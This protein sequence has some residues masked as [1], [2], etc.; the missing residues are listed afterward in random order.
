MKRRKILICLT[1]VLILMMPVNVF[2]AYENLLYFAD[3][4]EQNGD[5]A[6]ASYYE[7]GAAGNKAYVGT[8]S[9]YFLIQ[10]DGF[11]ICC[12]TAYGVVC[13]VGGW[14]QLNTY[15]SVYQDYDL[16]GNNWEYVY[17]VAWGD[18]FGA[19]LNMGEVYTHTVNSEKELLSLFDS[20]STVGKFYKSYD[21]ETSYTEAVDFFLKPPKVGKVQKILQALEMNQMNPLTEVLKILPIGLVCWVGWIGLR[22]GLSLLHQVLFQA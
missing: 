8:S 13:Y 6:L 16:I 18:S 21:T 15:T 10:D 11:Y 20:S 4:A 3:A 9:L 7:G 1:L 5:V 22:K 14:Y 19:T 17:F 12:D 2:A